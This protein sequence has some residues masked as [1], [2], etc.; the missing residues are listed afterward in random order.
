LWCRAYPSRTDRRCGSPKISI[1]VGDLGPCGE[2]EPFGIGIRARTHG[3][4]F[5]AWIPVL[6]RTASNDAVNCPARSR[7]RNRKPAARSPRSVRR[8]RICCVVH[9]PSQGSGKV[10]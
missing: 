1:R 2:H 3:R 9:G 6:A 7:T 8:L 4:I 10:R 5:T